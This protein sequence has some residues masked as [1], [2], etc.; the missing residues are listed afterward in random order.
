MQPFGHNTS[1]SQTDR[2]TDR[3]RTDSIGRTVSQTVVQ[4]RLLSPKCFEQHVIALHEASLLKATSLIR[5][6]KTAACDVVT[7]E[8]AWGK[9]VGNMLLVTRIPLSTH[10]ALPFRQR[11]R[12]F[13]LYSTTSIRHDHQQGARA[14]AAACWCSARRTRFHSWTVIRWFMWES[15]IM[16]TRCRRLCMP[17]LGRGRGRPGQHRR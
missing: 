3:Q 9:Y 6:Q 10:A 17:T 11:R 13:P 1:T 14:D 15:E 12:Q 7:A 5:R 2:Q 4:K 16:P 8:I